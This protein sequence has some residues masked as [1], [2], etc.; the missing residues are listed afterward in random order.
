MLDYFLK[1]YPNAKSELSNWD[2]AFQFLICIVLSAQTT[3]AMVNNVTGELF[4]R[5]PTPELLMMASVDDVLP[6]IRRVNYNRNKSKF[7]IALSRMIIEDFRGE[8]PKTVKELMKLP[9]VGNKTANVYL[10]DLYGMSEG[11]GVDTH[12]RRLSNRYGF[13]L[14]DDP[15]KIAKDLEGLFPKEHWAFINS[16]MVLYG[17][18]V[19]KAKVKPHE[20]ECVFDFCDWCNG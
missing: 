12:I 10:N 19:C 20:S 3:D 16:T 6:I 5:Y 17:R 1:T 15:D 14:H 13:S 7:I 8:V 4:E 11:I 2:S 18:Y 9:G